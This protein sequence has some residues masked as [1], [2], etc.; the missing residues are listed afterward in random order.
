MLKG[1]TNNQA[2]IL[3]RKYGYNQ[4]PEPKKVSALTILIK[5]FKSLLVII[6]IV[7]ATLSF[8]IG[9]P[10]DASFIVAVIIL[11]SLFGFAQEFRAEKAMQSLK[12]MITHEVRAFRDN[13]EILLE[14]KY[15]VP[16][17]VITL[18]EGSSV[19]ADCYLM[20]GSGIEVDESTL[21][22]ESLPVTKETGDNQEK[23]QLYMGTTVLKGVGRAQVHAIGSDT[24]FGKI[25]L[26]YKEIKD[27]ETP[28]QKQLNSLG[29]SLVIIVLVASTGVFIMGVLHQLDIITMLFTS[30]SLVV[31]VIP[32]GLPTVVTI[33]LALGMQRMGRKNALVRRL[34]AIET[35][36]ATTIICTDKTG[37]L[38]KNEMEVNH[39]WADYKINS[40][41]N[42]PNSL[43]VKKLMQIAI[44]ANHASLTEAEPNIGP[45]IIGDRTEG[46]LLL[47]ANKLG[48]L[49]LSNGGKI[50][51]EFPFDSQLKTM[52]VT[53]NEN[54]V[55]EIFSKGA[56]EIILENCNQILSKDKI[57]SLTNKDKQEIL[58]AINKE[59]ATGA[60]TLAFAFKE[61]EVLSNITRTQAEKNLVFI[62]FV[63][64]ADPIRPEIKNAISTAIQAGIKTIMITGDNPET[65][66]AIGIEAGIIKDSENICTGQQLDLMGDT[67]LKEAVQKITVFARI[68]PIQ[69]QRIIKILQATGHIVAVTGDGVNDTLSLKQAHVGVAMGK[70]GTDVARQAADIVLRDD[71]YA[72]LI[73]A[74]EEGRIIYDNILKAL[75]YLL[76]S[77][78]S[79][80][81]V[82]II[83]VFL[84][85]P[86]PLTPIQ[87]LWI[88]L[89]T[90][91]L[92]ALALATDPKDP[93]VMHRLP[94]NNTASIVKMLDPYWLTKIGLLVASLT[95]LSFVYALYFLPLPTA[96][97]VAF[98]VII[99][100][101]LVVA[102]AVRYPH[103]WHTNPRLIMSSVF[104]LLLQFLILT[105]GFLSKLFEISVHP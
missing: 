81:L 101:Q 97:G 85:I 10:L 76:S 53:W 50:V 60:R 28:L 23:G 37:T 98:T 17:D 5:Q 91:S 46:S 51:E 31:S 77:N 86:L 73:T 90:D 67:D 95:I 54:K 25:A 82:I 2:A 70:S 26:N 15:L 56:P 32:E 104:I 92:P 11:N 59:A 103:R 45:T 1:L 72:S 68:N 7:A 96:R 16:G 64:I 41:K 14:T 12:K 20:E 84:G 40:V 21:T 57:R 65:A 34:A 79:E 24:R 35:L 75:K 99:T 42:L 3:Q 80:M 27:E 94:R 36:G 62:G 66:R 8:I 47:L 63:S 55:T 100:M 88:N 89:V 93:L 105:N 44:S 39:V 74:I 6:L 61:K 78:F 48:L 69:K 18:E 13:K 22:G 29:K 58:N 38:T 102:F 83:A 87:I 30:I 33:T 52:T 43:A 4:L 19:P 71:N 49:P 9:D